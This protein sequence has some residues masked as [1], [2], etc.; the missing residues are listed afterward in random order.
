MDFLIDV[1]E[2][3][4]LRTLHFES[5]FT[6]GAMRIE[7][8][9]DLALEYTRVMMACLLLR[10]RDRFPEN[11][12]LIGL[13]AGSLTKFLYRHY[14]CTQLTVVEIEPRVVEVARESFHLPLDADR[15]DIVIG[16]GAEYVRNTDKTF[17]LIMVDG[18]NERGH[19]GELNTLPFYQACR[20]RL[21]GKGVLVTNLVGVSHG[22]KGGFG[23]I[24]RA[25]DDR[26]VMFPRCKTGN[27]IAFAATGERIDLSL[28]ELTCRAL[29]LHSRT[30]LAL[31]PTV[32]TLDYSSACR[33]GKLVL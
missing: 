3:D 5:A 33:E 30:G 26:A 28:G 13:G 14:P 15:L 1:R 27:T 17:D 4:G 8:P 29:D 31:L 20:T 7:R 11:A 32:S 22:S 9:W 18:F 21:S 6:Q 25:F 10:D 19:T 2:K 24:E 12:L 16:D 23:H